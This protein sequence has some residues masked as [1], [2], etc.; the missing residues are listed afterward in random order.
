[1]DAPS[2]LDRYITILFIPVI[3]LAIVLLPFIAFALYTWW[4]MRRR[5]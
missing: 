3:G 2:L 5:R 1:M 4:S